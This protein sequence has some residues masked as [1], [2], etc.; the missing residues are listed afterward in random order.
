MGHTITGILLA[1]GRGRR[2]DPSGARNKLLQRLGDG[3]LVAVASARRLLAVLPQV[4]AVVRPGDE[5]VATA[6]QQLGC[7]VVVCPD[8]DAGMGVSL[9]YALAHAAE[10]DG[11]LIALAD[12]PYVQSAT[13]AKL[14]A[15]LIEGA[16]IALPRCEGERGNP[17]GFGRQHLPALL[18]LDGDQGARAIVKAHRAIEVD[19]SDLG[20]FR[21]V[22][23]PLDLPAS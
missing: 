17:V 14:C 19:V 20:I 3:E 6:L 18:A 15:A 2:F 23:T 7:E 9:R 21:D 10:A 13:I 4:L 5:A 11:W 12:M 1:A 8:A 22:D 16:A